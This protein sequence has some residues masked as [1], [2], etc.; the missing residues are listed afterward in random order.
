[1]TTKPKLNLSYEGNPK[2]GDTM[3]TNSKPKSNLIYE[4]LVDKLAERAYRIH[5]DE[6][7]LDWEECVSQVVEKDLLQGA[8]EHLPADIL[9]RMENLL[10]LE[11]EHLC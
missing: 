4:E 6:P 2:G 1:M 7:L 8:L 11:E 5:K 3:T 10:E 9:S